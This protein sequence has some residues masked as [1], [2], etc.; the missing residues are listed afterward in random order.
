VQHV[1]MV[2]DKLKQAQLHASR[3]KSESFAASIDATGHI[4]DDQGLRVLSEK[5]ARIEAWT[6]LKNNK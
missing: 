1:A 5:L 3:K 6:T 2:C 4:I